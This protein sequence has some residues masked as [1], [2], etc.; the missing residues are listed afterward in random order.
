MVG[1][2]SSAYQEAYTKE[3]VCFTAGPE[4]GTLTGHSFII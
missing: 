2:I 3:K 4:F 1:D